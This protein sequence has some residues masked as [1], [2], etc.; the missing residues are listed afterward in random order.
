[1]YQKFDIIWIY[2][3]GVP[4]PLVEPSVSLGL[5]LTLDVQANFGAS[6]G[7]DY[8]YHVRGGVVF[9]THVCSYIV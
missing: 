1:M 7:F 3:Y 9:V 2:P 5:E 4:V 6:F 8:S